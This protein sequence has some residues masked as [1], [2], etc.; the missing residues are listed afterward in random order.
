MFWYFDSSSHV[1][2]LT[3]NFGII[4][5]WLNI[6][7]CFGS[8][9][10]SLFHDTLYL[11]MYL[12]DKVLFKYLIITNTISYFQNA[13]FKISFFLYRQ[14]LYIL[15]VV[16]KNTNCSSRSSCTIDNGAMVQRITENQT[17]LHIKIVHSSKSLARKIKNTL[18]P[19][20]LNI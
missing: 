3:Y 5:V 16:L 8:K 12:N 13:H 15:T 6:F 4:L 18:L 7:S 2:S 20:A 1:L 9:N 11:A 17:S 14:T 10:L 19:G